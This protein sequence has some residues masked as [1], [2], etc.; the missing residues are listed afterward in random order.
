MQI[1][2]LYAGRGADRSRPWPVPK[3]SEK[4]GVTMEYLHGSV[5][6][7]WILDQ[8]QVAA[9]IVGARYTRHLP[10]KLLTLHKVAGKVSAKA[11]TVFA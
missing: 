2:V 7:R 11:G 1:C 3:N 8:P 4:Q 9:A 5:T 6:T 10:S